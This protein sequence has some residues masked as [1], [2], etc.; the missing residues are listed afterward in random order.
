MTGLVWKCFPLSSRVYVG[1]VDA[2]VKQTPQLSSVQLAAIACRVFLIFTG[3]VLL[4]D[5]LGHTGLLVLADCGLP[6]P[7]CGCPHTLTTHQLMLHGLGVEVDLSQSLAGSP[8]RLGLSELLKSTALLSDLI[9]F[10]QGAMREDGLLSGWCC[11]LRWLC[12]PFLRTW[13]GLR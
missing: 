5:H 1:E 13:N 4:L 10:D 12:Y 6:M 11:T 2:S 9:F 3:V 8:V 7:N